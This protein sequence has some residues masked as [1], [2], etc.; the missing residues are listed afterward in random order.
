MNTLRNDAVAA[1]ALAVA[2][3]AALPAASVRAQAWP[4]KPLSLVVA[5]SAGGPTDTLARI[6]AERLRRSLGP[7]GGG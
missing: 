6:T 2:L 4:N 5:F 1:V 7:D 3:T